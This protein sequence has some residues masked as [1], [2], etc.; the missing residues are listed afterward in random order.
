M[1]GSEGLQAR[2]SMTMALDTKGTAEP[3]VVGISAAVA[4]SS[5]SW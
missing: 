1:E 3:V 5:D 2:G 4:M